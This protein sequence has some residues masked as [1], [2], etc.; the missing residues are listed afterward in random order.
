MRLDRETAN[1]LCTVCM[2]TPAG[3]F[4]VHPVY[5]ICISNRTLY[6][7]LQNLQLNLVNSDAM[8]KIMHGFIIMKKKTNEPRNQ[9]CGSVDPGGSTSLGKILINFMKS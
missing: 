1:L 5:T 2:D 8:L 6:T 7:K 9:C 4:M 3:R